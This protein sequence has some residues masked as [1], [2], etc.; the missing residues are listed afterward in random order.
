MKDIHRNLSFLPDWPHAESYARYLEQHARDRAESHA[1]EE[2]R[3]D[4][5]ILLGLAVILG[6]PALA[7]IVWVLKPALTG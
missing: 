3:F 6:V 5:L 1:R 7:A 2:Q 4:W